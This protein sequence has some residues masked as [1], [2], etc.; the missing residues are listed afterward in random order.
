[1]EESNS[2]ELLEK[3]KLLINY[4][5][6]KDFTN[7]IKT[8]EDIRNISGR[9][10]KWNDNKLMSLEAK[11][12]LD[13][14]NLEEAFN[15]IK[16]AFK[17]SEG[18]DPEINSNLRAISFKLLNKLFTKYKISKNIDDLSQA[19]KT[20]NE[21][22][23][24]NFLPNEMKENLPKIEFNLR[25]KQFS[26]YKEAKNFDQ[27]IY[28]INEI[29][30]IPLDSRHNEFNDINLMNQEAIIELEKKE[31]E[32]AFIKI[33]KALQMSEGKDIK[34]NKNYESIGG[35][36]IKEK[37]KN[38][39]YDECEKLI[40]KYLSN[41][42]FNIE[43]GENYRYQYKGKIRLKK[44]DYENA[45]NIFYEALLNKKYEDLTILLEDLI[46]AGNKIYERFIANNKFKEADNSYKK[47]LE[48]INDDNKLK[49][50][51]IQCIIINM[52][53]KRWEEAHKI[54]CSLNNFEDDVN[55][56][57]LKES[58][59]NKIISEC[60]NNGD[61][62]KSED[63]IK[64][65][66]DISPS[67]AL[68]L[69]MEFIKKKISKL[70]KSKDYPKIIEFIDK[71]LSQLDKNKNLQFYFYLEDL[72][73]SIKKEELQE[74]YKNGKINEYLNEV[75]KSSGEE[76]QEKQDIYNLASEIFNDEAE[77]DIEEGNLEKAEEKINKGLEKNPDNINLINTK[78]AL[79]YE[80]GNLNEAL[81][82][83]NK[84][85][86]KDPKNTQLKRN[87]LNI[88]EKKLE[89]HDKNLSENEKK[90]VKD[91]CFNSENKSTKI[92]SIDM[93]LQISN[94][95][96]IKFENNEVGNL[97][98]N[99]N[100]EENN[101]LEDIYIMSKTALLLKKGLN[102]NNSIELDDRTKEF[103]E[104]GLNSE[105]KGTKNNLLS[106]Y[107]NISNLSKK[108]MEKPIELIS[109]NLKFSTNSKDTKES[110]KVLEHFV[111]QEKNLNL[112]QEL[113]TNLIQNLCENDFTK[114]NNEELESSQKSIFDNIY[115]EVIRGVNQKLGNNRH[116]LLTKGQKENLDIAK[117]TVNII[118]NICNSKEGLSETDLENI[119]NMVQKSNDYS[120]SKEFN[121]FIKKEAINIVD[122]SLKKKSD[123]K[124]PENLINE[125]SK[126][127]KGKRQKKVLTILDKVS[128]NQEITK[129]MS[130]NLIN[131]LNDQNQ[132]NQDDNIST[133]SDVSDINDTF[134]DEDEKYNISMRI[135]SKQEDKLNEHQKQ[136]LEIEKNT[137]NLKAE[138]NGNGI[139]ESINN[140]N[141]IVDKGYQINKH[142][143]REIKKLLSGND[144]KIIES[145]S[146]LINTMT[147]NG[148]QV[149]E[150]ISNE[151]IDKIKN[152]QNLSKNNMKNLTANLI[153]IISKYDVPKESINAFSSILKK[154]K[155]KKDFEEIEMAITGLNILSKMHYVMNPESIDLCLDIISTKEFNDKTLNE[156]SETLSNI[157]LE[158][159]INDSTFNKLFDILNNNK[160][161]YNNLSVCLYNHLKFK[162]QEKI[163]EL[164]KNNLDN[165]ENVIKS[166]YF[167]ENILNILKKSPKI[168]ANRE[169]LK[170]CLDFDELCS[171]LEKIDNQDEK[172]KIINELYNYRPFKNFTK[173]HFSI[174]QNN[175]CCENSINIIKEILDKNFDILKNEINIEKIFNSNSL[176]LSGV[177]DILI[178][179][180]SKGNDISDDIL[181]QLSKIIITDNEDVFKKIIN[182]FE[183]IKKLR[184]I[185]DKIE[186]QIQLEK[187]NILSIDIINYLINIIKDSDLI[188]K[189]YIEKIYQNFDNNDKR[190]ILTKLIIYL[191]NKNISLPDEIIDKLCL[192]NKD[193]HI[194]E[195]IPIILSNENISNNHE[196]IF[197][198]KLV[199][200]LNKKNETNIIQK[201]LDKFLLYC[202]FSNFSQKLR[203]FVILNINKISYNKTDY[204]NYLYWI[205]D[206]PTGDDLNKIVFDQIKN[207][208]YK[209]DFEQLI[210]LNSNS[211]RRKFLL[212]ENYIIDKLLEKLSGKDEKIKEYILKICQINNIKKNNFSMVS[213]IKSFINQKN[214]YDLSKEGLEIC[215][216]KYLQM[217]FN[218]DKLVEDIKNKTCFNHIRKNWIINQMKI[219]KIENLKILGMDIQDYI[220]NKFIEFN[221]CDKLIEHFFGLIDIEFYNFDAGIYDFFEFI[222]ENISLLENLKQ[223]IFEVPKS[224]SFNS[225]IQ[226]IKI[227]Y[228][229]KNCRDEYKM[230]FCRIFILNNWKLYNIQ[231]FIK[232]KI[233]LKP[234]GDEDLIEEIKKVIIQNEL[235]F[236]TKAKEGCIF[237]GCNL[238]NILEKYE[239]KDWELAI[240]NL[241]VIQKLEDKQQNDIDSLLN[242]IKEKNPNVSVDYLNK[243]KEYIQRIRKAYNSPIQ[244]LSSSN[245]YNI[246]NISKDKI[247][248]FTKTDI[249]NWS[250]SQRTKKL[251]NE[252]ESFLI[253][254]LA[255]INRAY[256]I[257]TLSKTEYGY[258]VR[259]V[260][261]LSILIMLLKPKNKGMFCQIN[262]G[263]GK[264]SIVSI[265]ATIKALQHD[266]VDVLSSSI[267]LAKRDAEEKKD[268]Y[269][270]F[271]LT[272]SSTDDDG[273]YKC[274]I[275]YGDSL[276][277]EGDVLREMFHGEGKRMENP[278][279][280]F[281]QII[282]DEVDSL[283]IDKLSACTRLCAPFPSYSFLAILYPF[284]YNNLN[285]IDNLIEKNLFK[286][287]N[288]EN[289][290][291]FTV[292]KLKE[293]VRD[294][295]NK[296][297]K[298]FDL[299]D[300]QR[301]IDFIL[302]INLKEFIELQ[303]DG[304]CESA[305]TAKHYYKENYHYVIAKE[306]NS[307]LNDFLKSKG[308]T[309]RDKYLISPVDFSNTG[310]VDLHMKWSD[311]LTQF[312]QIKHGLPIS[313]EDLTTTYLSHYNFLKKYI[314]KNENNIF[315]VT[316]TLGS[317][318]SKNLLSTLFNVDI[319]IIPPFK[320]SRYISLLSK[321]GFKDR[322]QWKDAILE[323]IEL[324]TNRKRVVLLICY[325]I[326]E[327]DELYDYLKSKNYNQNLMQKYQRNDI[328]TDIMSRKHD[329]GEVIFATNLA[330]RGTDI[331]LTDLVEK[332]GGMH[333]IV[334]FLPSNS[335]VEQQA[336]GRTARSG[337]NGS[338]NLIIN[339]ERKV[340]LLKN[341]RDR[342]ED[343]R[344]RNIKENE[345][346]NLEL[347]GDLFEKFTSLYRNIEKSKSS[348]K[349]Q[350][351]V[352]EKWGIWL[353]RN[354]LE[355]KDDNL[356]K[357]E[358]YKLY[359]KFK[360]D[361]ENNYKNI[362]NPFNYLLRDYNEEALKIDEKT[363][364]YAVFKK[365]LINVDGSKS[366]SLKKDAC[367]AIEKTI[368]FIDDNIIPQLHG[369][370]SISKLSTNKC[371]KFNNTLKKDLE[372]DIQLKADTFEKLKQKLKE[373]SKEIEG[374][375]DNE[376]AIVH[377]NQYGIKKLT[378][379]LDTVFYFI[380]LGIELY[381]TIDIEIE[382][383]YWGIFCCMF[384]GVLQVVGGCML[385][386]FTGNDFGLIK[387]GLSDIK[388]GFECLIGKKQFSWKT[389]G[390]KKKAFL[391]NLAIN[392][393]VGYFTGSLTSVPKGDTS[394]KDLLIK[395]GAHAVKEGIN[396]A[397][398][399]LIGKDLI[400]S[401]FDKVKE[402]I[403]L[404]SAI[405]NLIDNVCQ[406]IFKNPIFDKMLCLDELQEEKDNLN[407]FFKKINKT[408]DKI[409][410]FSNSIKMFIQVFKSIINT[411]KSDE[412]WFL[413]L[414]NIFKTTIANFKEL[415][416]SCNFLVHFL[417]YFNEEVLGFLENY[418][419]GFSNQV[420]NFEDYI[421]KKLLGHNCNDLFDL[422]KK[423]HLIN[424][425]GIPN[426]NLIL[427]DGKKHNISQVFENIWKKPENFFNKCYDNI[428]I[429]DKINN[430]QS[431]INNT[432]HNISDLYGEYKSKGIDLINQYNDNLKNKIDMFSD[433]ELL[434]EINYDNNFSIDKIDFGKYSDKKDEIINKLKN[435]MLKLENFDINKT[436]DEIIKKIKFK[437]QESFNDLLIKALNSTEFGGYIQN[438]SDKYEDIMNKIENY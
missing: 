210:Y 219:K 64:K 12:E 312:L 360:L 136:I 150:K 196:N 48:V 328:E 242:E 131:I 184:N 287:F 436:K 180:I 93:M 143:E 98:Q 339:D 254:A 144:N 55:I 247:S 425:F 282:I 113:K 52:N 237:G 25:H 392:L 264:S 34:I 296:N 35:N 89:S 412:N 138:S 238:I 374:V 408:L 428:G 70:F 125:I 272:V 227:L 235:S 352:E 427:N 274:N 317:T 251:I 335:R 278:K 249:L 292:E 417:D 419:Q 175:I 214:N 124:L 396:T 434:E 258:D 343:Q 411:I 267:V 337:K 222:K 224:T 157:F 149:N 393:V 216:G 437:I 102:E 284:I 435:T 248:N 385:K 252:D 401:V 45:F 75:S 165:L 301:K 24:L 159:D 153:N 306:E 225:L 11:I 438:L 394:V 354:K 123:Q 18:K 100:I 377:I 358:I 117:T 21:L 109:D 77:K 127:V 120:N 322:I 154:Y 221:F 399:N 433:N 421:N 273:C 325:T 192:Y 398:E 92:K 300:E 119:G 333:V 42:Y 416:E 355:G 368:K 356:N 90:F 156:L 261:L 280:G 76:S 87:K 26:Y 357:E 14:G 60:F 308:F 33:E 230:G 309:V 348:P 218:I 72:K 111:K 53:Y 345:I 303:I 241:C 188:P 181:F 390:E 277:F 336:V 97:L 253:E 56:K 106:I 135:L 406:N 304:W 133:I 334:T 404:N 130:Y 61:L 146:N 363:C 257:D 116:K 148:V 302:P 234:N 198:E 176:N 268:F 132:N 217:E 145:T 201:I 351:D 44:H 88:L 305:F 16:I 171:K 4:M 204:G 147:K 13:K 270:L 161:L 326:E 378:T 316:G 95:D 259:D 279:R 173:K 91:I 200:Y 172:I 315:G 423:N 349:F 118:K 163:D 160:Q 194:I 313:S 3:I 122:L 318:E 207:S 179:N 169:N 361:I 346:K 203:E 269:S 426:G 250:Q 107:K 311:G 429:S 266:Y 387:E 195:L 6:Q 283:Y 85:L 418:T 395:A 381:Y 71:N 5:K 246:D 114:E 341:I 2:K 327:A 295:L 376:D 31:Y 220:Y 314:K 74:I 1:M 262:T 178:L 38:E 86:L 105:Y 190:E 212:D 115:D 231:K 340:K 294:L 141:C 226:K 28:I 108:D 99:I 388:Y 139:L 193:E 362:Q 23:S 84:V 186:K 15:K 386:V 69:K 66:E 229:S 94:K 298:G 47:I 174:L 9:P 255:I 263:E 199:E 291:R 380:D 46:H 239:R 39:K 110:I 129:D 414:T 324:N 281:F 233:N 276:G 78:A 164:L 103:L 197:E 265:L 43:N 397:V 299:E 189:R 162:S 286:D 80:K 307:K 245:Q 96:H 402:Y 126:E 73:K 364:F 383:N 19:E 40:D 372:E 8:I 338:G 32:K 82:D 285:M 400:K 332:N 293:S 142:T 215:L 17:N 121:K 323:D 431:H 403:K 432:I 320:P 347:M 260:Q 407:I 51:K 344:I 37:Y 232:S 187:E 379:D 420:N 170:K 128:D 353:K 104:K 350:E 375:I 158:A 20:I 415:K 50:Y 49:E 367:I 310:V 202:K 83:I 81:E 155:D 370:L 151:I 58:I 140:I 422:L 319:C 62:D 29:R 290:H 112:N 275:V 208:A 205:F 243:L 7:A 240:K 22:K 359:D 271:G 430:Y 79:N 384:L 211:D 30:K 342:R 213:L 382:K 65:L 391:V 167:N 183:S 405:N 206:S 191:M 329:A 185:P 10:Q 36:L 54:I 413:K 166:G 27:V 101:N 236:N 288:E 134:D 424:K 297:E 389:Y 67:K 331:G 410:K 41:G 409:D 228:V 223:I 152:S 373:A 365:A 68:S 256:R 330:G 137:Q 366:Y 321:S 371:F 182:I 244:G 57:I 369:M 209:N 59:L 289:R 168:I 63:Y 177:L